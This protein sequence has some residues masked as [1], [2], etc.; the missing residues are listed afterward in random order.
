VVWGWARK[1]TARNTKHRNKTTSLRRKLKKK[2]ERK[3]Y[4]VYNK[5]TYKE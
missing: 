5:N 2:K 4:T 3:V 1:V